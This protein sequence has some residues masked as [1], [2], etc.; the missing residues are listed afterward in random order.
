MLDQL[1]ELKNAQPFERFSIELSSGRVLPVNTADH[2]AL[3][4]HGRG[5]VAVY[6]DNGVFVIVS[7]LHIASIHVNNGNQ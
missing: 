4:E 7:G 6:T 1:R 3:G 5:R 2:I